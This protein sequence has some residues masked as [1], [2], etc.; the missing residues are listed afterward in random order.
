M[1]L[2]LTTL[3]NGLQQIL[4]RPLDKCLITL[5][6]TVGE[7]L[8][9]CTNTLSKSLPL[10]LANV[11]AGS[12][13]IVNGGGGTGQS[14]VSTIINALHQ[15][16]GSIIGQVN[17]IVTALVINLTHALNVLNPLIGLLGKK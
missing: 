15:L 12:N 4:T 14:S 9:S 13:C 5:L 11:T 3:F 17:T 2:T 8:Q 1:G 7:N 6:C 10:I 16:L